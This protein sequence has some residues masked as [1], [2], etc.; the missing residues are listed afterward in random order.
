MRKL[1]I[2][3]GALSVFWGSNVKADETLSVAFQEIE[4]NYVEKVSLE[5]LSVIALK[6]L[7]KMDKNIQV[8][9]GASRIT[10]YYNTKVFK[11]FNKPENNNLMDWVNLIDN[12]VAAY[13]RISKKIALRDYEVTDTMLK[14]VISS[15]DNDSKYYT[16]FDL[17]D[18]EFE[19][20]R[21][22]SSRRIGE[23]LY[24]RMSG[25]SDDVVN[26]FAE[27]LQQE[28][29]AQGLILDLR[30][31]SGGALNAV[32]KIGNMLLDGGVMFESYGRDTTMNLLYE[33]DKNDDF[34]EKP[35]VV[36][37]DGN[38]A[39]SAEILA[40]VLQ[41]QSR[42]VLMGAQTYGKAT[43][44][45]IVALPNGSV[46][47]LT[48]AYLSLPSGYEFFKKGLKPDYCLNNRVEF[49]INTKMQ[50]C[51]KENRGEYDEDIDS[52][53]EVIKMRI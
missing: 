31:N 29:I 51:N 45:K 25:F 41:E 30:G 23:I 22:F 50:N 17:A 44:Q 32:V 26:K 16:A 48:N 33:A 1:V 9:D 3:F 38:T 5:Q 27:V 43:S 47:M 49:D 20:K 4:R 42:A 53:I 14:G 40:G 34:A 46:L 8:A 7:K 36:L 18:D 37:V 12:I 52:A 15:L 2:L 28:N 24:V 13:A 39:S 35:I 10:L 21:Y 6:S 19:R 11:N